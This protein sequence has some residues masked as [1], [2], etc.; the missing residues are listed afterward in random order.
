MFQGHTTHEQAGAHKLINLP[1]LIVLPAAHPIFR[2]AL[3]VRK[4]AAESQ[5]VEHHC[6]KR[7]KS[8]TGRL[9]CAVRV[10]DARP[11]SADVGL[12]PHGVREPLQCRPLQH[13][14]RIQ[15]QDEIRDARAYTLVAGCGKT[16]VLVVLNELHRGK[17]A[18]NH[19]SRAI[20]GGI[21]DN[22][23][24]WGVTLRSQFEKTSLQRRA[25]VE[26]DNDNSTD[27]IHQ[28]ERDPYLTI[29][30]KSP[31]CQFNTVLGFQSEPIC[32]NNRLKAV[33]LAG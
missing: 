23:D 9:Q 28:T 21:V 11:A 15:Q 13:G 7:W 18:C 16:A 32:R 5:F 24:R 27:W 10:D 3:A 25:A 1:G 26:T 30:L 19:F 33:R 20:G 8:A 17:V 6:P 4:D 29:T 22:D 2:E 31:F 14:V 12:R